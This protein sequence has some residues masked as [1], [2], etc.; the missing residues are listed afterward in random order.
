MK[1]LIY[2]K[3]RDLKPEGGPSGYLYSLKN[4]LDREH[5]EWI[6]FAKD[7]PGRAKRLFYKLPDP[8]ENKIK[9]IK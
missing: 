9:R 8:I 2:F 3:E 4:E 6:H 7:N 5:V 1:E